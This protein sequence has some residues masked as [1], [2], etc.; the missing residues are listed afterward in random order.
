MCLLGS[1]NHDSEIFEKP[2]E[3]Q[4][5]RYASNEAHNSLLL[6]EIEHL[7]EVHISAQVH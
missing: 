6:V 4:I 1:A 5:D 7:E 2:D 3:F